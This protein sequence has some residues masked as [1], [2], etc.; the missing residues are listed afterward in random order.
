MKTLMIVTLAL[1]L[2]LQAATAANPG[3][4]PASS[5]VAGQKIDSGLGEL[6]NYRQWADP[7]GKNPMVKPAAAKAQHRS[8]APRITDAKAAAAAPRQ[9]AGLK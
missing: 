2:P 4:A 8:K 9:V 7:S 5:A 3:A 1:A 6:P